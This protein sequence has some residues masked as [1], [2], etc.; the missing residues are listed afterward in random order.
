M[1]M[2]AASNK[3]PAKKPSKATAKKVAARRRAVRPEGV[4][5]AD[6]VF[7]VDAFRARLGC[8]ASTVAEMRRRGLV[9]RQDGGRLKIHG[10]DYLDYVA[11]L[12]AAPLWGRG[13]DGSKED[14]K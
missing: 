9:V 7:T 5:R 4:I 3:M 10:R 2:V 12:P 14:A 6:E 1:Q 8:K 13:G 11:S